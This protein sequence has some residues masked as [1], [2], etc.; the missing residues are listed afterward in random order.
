MHIDRKNVNQIILQMRKLMKQINLFVITL[1]FCFISI[2]SSAQNST[3]T[4]YFDSTWNPTSKDAAF[5]FTEMIKVDTFY[6][7]T[8]YWMKSKKLFCKSA[9][10]DTLFANPVGLLIRYYENGK[11]ED[12][13]YFNPDGTFK[14][15]Y[16]YYN[17]GK[18][19]VHYQNSLKS[20][21][22][23]TEAY[24]INGNRIDDFI[25]SKEASFQ[26]GS[27]EWKS[28]IAQNLKTTVP[29]TKGAPI[30]TYQVV[31]NFLVR[32]SGKLTDIEAETNLGFGMEDEVMRVIRKSPK[33]NPAVLMGKT[34]DAYRRQPIT[35]VVT[36]E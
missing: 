30:G 5:Y 18:I 2:S 12:S 32:K 31:V 27:A 24:D 34:V 26:E 21:K 36:K 7:C 15:T 6:K 11:I 23:I 13:S 16:H 17:N 14:N 22:E 19:W 3:L 33:W 8:S 9:Y 20:K 1:I 35:F 28:F 10:A 4:K 29:V 25:Y